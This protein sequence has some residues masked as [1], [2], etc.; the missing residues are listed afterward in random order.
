MPERKPVD[1]AKEIA[2][3]IEQFEEAWY[4]G[5]VPDI[6][7][8]LPDD[9]SRATVLAELAC[10]D[11][12]FRLKSGY[13]ARVEDYFERYPALAEN[14]GIA[15]E[16]ITE[17]FEFRRRREPDLSASA[18]LDRF[19]EYRD[20]LVSTLSELEAS[21]SAPESS[22]S[23]VGDGVS[24]EAERPLDDPE[25]PNRR[26]R[27]LREH[28]HGGLGVIF[29]ARDEE[30]GRNVALKQIR[31]NRATDEGCRSRFLR[32][33]RITATLEHPGTV[34]I[35]GLGTFA[36]GRPFYV[37]RFVG[38]K[39]A[40]L[41]ESIRKLHGDSSNSSGPLSRNAEFR[42]LL[43]RFINVCDAIQYAH[44]QGVLH[45][46]VKPENIML[47][48]Y[49]ETLVVD[50]GLAKRIDE[51]DAE[52]IP[53]PSTD[54]AE[55][56]AAA[57]QVGTILGSPR[58]ISP[59]QA[60]GQIGELGHATDIYGLGATLYMLL[61]GRDAHFDTT[62][63]VEVL[64]Q[65]RKGEFR[66]PCE[67]SRQVPK[68]L[69]AVCLRAMALE[70]ED[71]YPTAR[72]LAD[73]IRRWLNDEP[74]DVYRDPLTVRVGRFCRR[75]RTL[76]AAT[77][78]LVMTALVGLL[79]S[80]VLIS[81]EK[82]KVVAAHEAEK[83][84]RQE[85]KNA[86]EEAERQREHAENTFLFAQRSLEEYFD[87]FGRVDWEH[88][89]IADLRDLFE[90]A[91]DL[92]RI[93]AEWERELVKDKEHLQ[94]RPSVY[95][96]YARALHN[97]AFVRAKLESTLAS[98]GLYRKAAGAYGKLAAEY[99]DNRDYNA[100]FAGVL[101]ELGARLVE[102]GEFSDA[103]ESLEEAVEL[104]EK[105]AA[106]DPEDVTLAWDLS[107]THQNLGLLHQWRGELPDART[108]LEKARELRQQAIESIPASDVETIFLQV[109]LAG[110]R[111]DLA[112]LYRAEGDLEKGKSELI[113]NVAQL[114]SLGTQLED[115]DTENLFQ[116]L[117]TD[118]QFKLGG[119]Y[120]N[121]GLLHSQRHDPTEGMRM[122]EKA[123]PLLDQLDKRSVRYRISLAR[124]Y[125]NLAFAHIELE[126]YDEAETA[127]VKARDIHES[128]APSQ[129][130]FAL[131]Q[132]MAALYCALARIYI[133]QGDKEKALEYLNHAVPI[134]VESIGVAPSNA[135]I[136]SLLFGTD[137]LRAGLLIREGRYEDAQGS[138]D[139]AVLYASTSSSTGR[140]FA[141]LSRAAVL[142]GTGQHI[143]AVEEAEAA[144][145]RNE[146][147]R[148]NSTFCVELARVYSL[149]SAAAERD[150]SLEE[151]KRDELRAQYVE[152][153]LQL[154]RTAQSNG[155]FDK[156]KHVEEF[157]D[158]S[159][160]DPIRD[161]DELKR[162][163]RS[164]GTPDSVGE[165]QTVKFEEG[166]ISFEMPG[167]PDE[168]TGNMDLPTG[169]VKC[170]VFTVR[171]GPTQYNVRIADLPAGE[172]TPDDERPFDEVRLM[173]RSLGELLDETKVTLDG[174]DG[175]EFL[176]LLEAGG[177][178]YVRLRF[179]VIDRRMCQFQVI[180]RQREASPAAKQ[181]LNSAKLLKDS[182]PE[183]RPSG[184]EA[185][186]GDA[187][188]PS[189]QERPLAFHTLPEDGEWIEFDMKQESSDPRF[190]GA[191]G[192]VRISAVGR[193]PRMGSECQWVEVESTIA[194]PIGDFTTVTRVLVDIK[195]FERQGTLE[196][197]VV[198]ASQKMPSEPMTPLKGDE[199]VKFIH[200]GV[201]KVDVE[202][203]VYKE[204]APKES[205]TTP[206][207]QFTTRR[208]VADYETATDDGVRF[209]LTC[210]K[211]P[212]V[213][214]GFAK[215]SQEIKGQDGSHFKV[216]LVAARKG[217]RSSGKPATAPSTGK[218]QASVGGKNA[219]GK[220]LVIETDRG[221]IVCDLYPED[222]PKTV[223][224][225]KE[226][227]RTGFY[228]GLTFHRVVPGFVVQGGDPK[229]DG[230][231]GSGA[232]L[233]AE[234]NSRKHVEG[235]LARAGGSEPDS[236]DSQFFISLGR[237]SHLDGEFTIF[238]QVVTG[239][240]VVRRIQKGDKMVRVYVR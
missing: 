3:I 88:L 148:S 29:E 102:L 85:E 225:I 133:E 58:F 15:L 171:S 202:R 168:Q 120:S 236:S 165:W 145:A 172:P 181:F 126:Q 53:T 96:A 65:V 38:G 81:R 189:G 72:E 143:Q 91:D 50:W 4:E 150:D 237:H 20:R 197:N 157:Q 228:D 127:C 233:P 82:A 35:Y 34:P 224:R 208:V 190:T 66:R 68:P 159:G 204:K 121:L 71:R 94:D 56:G 87:F 11:L 7:D 211:T 144:I 142:A 106:Y 79:V 226:L 229:G 210:W 110:T 219:E 180:G 161:R 234:S 104:Q 13:S 185:G 183:A 139:R 217:K 163:L 134:L 46:D 235:A 60:A 186:I 170:T 128:L 89:K 25:L 21:S 122:L 151:S 31:E 169:S 26:F 141:E 48:E 213:P 218:G 97:V 154:L 36:D 131:D 152:K 118:L 54:E 173:C 167:K 114:E 222:A 28:A 132:D 24:A 178:V 182:D 136:Q 130:L 153:A 95:L 76:V 227:C 147:G 83:I 49:G 42:E 103:A 9:D 52:A 230:T 18:F 5:R 231:G 232:H 112:A 239:M 113:A 201:Y 62:D 123:L 73:D 140:L 116:D 8:F 51:E 23:D 146:T 69:E 160:F 207:G 32:E 98:V 6:D 27:K 137:L 129:R 19:S 1:D 57:T 30:L 61:A 109:E 125:R 80:N 199:L 191:R 176:V 195:G 39:G 33:A 115:L 198:E 175:R 67:V 184:E 44:D 107:S 206:L 92:E 59:E 162:L 47:G 200:T 124:C 100:Y 187:E 70:P 179:F 86:R 155:Y 214:F 41:D 174:H 55:A 156:A 138:A 223:A 63:P 177:G 45:R 101:S 64:V 12:E 16:L 22:Q 74:V 221:T 84:A 93:L 240:S 117:A 17:E 10:T 99:P 105:L 215:F 149:A 220:T 205:L 209:T 166:E 203:A 90:L 212:A 135:Q 164:E 196:G 238:G 158:D 216:D 108:S 78:V 192:T 119:S 194:S 111:A 40:T 37:M 14:E 193:E 43:R 75:H 2:E 188:T 77:A